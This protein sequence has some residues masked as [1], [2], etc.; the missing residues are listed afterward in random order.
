MWLK[1]RFIYLMFIFVIMA[2]GGLS[3]CGEDYSN[4]IAS[5]QAEVN[6]L[7]AD[8]QSDELALWNNDGILEAEAIQL[9]DADGKMRAS[10]ATVDGEVVFMLINAND[11]PVGFLVVDSEGIVG[12]YFYSP[13]RDKPAES[14]LGPDSLLLLGEDAMAGF[15][16]SLEDIPGLLMSNPDGAAVYARVE[17]I[18]GK[19]AIVFYDEEDNVIFSSAWSDEPELE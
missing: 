17:V 4:E 10:L 6:S 2:I 13:E 9:V 16:I 11:E 8:I 5:L 7:E 1:S 3:G 14:S 15:F 18:N 19:T 12:L